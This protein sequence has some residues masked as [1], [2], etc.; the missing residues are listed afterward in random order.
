MNQKPATQGFRRFASKATL[1]IA[2]IL[3]IGA[4]VWLGGRH[5]SANGRWLP[6]SFGGL[7]VVMFLVIV[8]HSVHEEHVIKRTV[9]QALQGR[10]PFRDEDFGKRFYA[11]DLSGLAAQLRRL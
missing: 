2:A 10:D 1:T 3:I 4:G 11:K 6:L 8:V 7:V 9:A 5:L